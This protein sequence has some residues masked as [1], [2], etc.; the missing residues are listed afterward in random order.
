SIS[1]PLHASSCICKYIIELL[2]FLFKFHDQSRNHSGKSCMQEIVAHYSGID[3][4]I[5]KERLWL[6]VYT[7]CSCANE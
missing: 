6:H 7:S 5:F 3:L 1:F 2:I 4:I